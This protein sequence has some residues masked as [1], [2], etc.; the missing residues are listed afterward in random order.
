MSQAAKLRATLKRGKGKQVFS[1]DE[2][3]LAK[4]TVLVWL[5]M[6]LRGLYI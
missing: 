6:Q 4:A 2:R 3:S 1:V 5:S